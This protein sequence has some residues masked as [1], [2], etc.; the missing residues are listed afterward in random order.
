MLRLIEEGF[1]GWEL[2]PLDVALAETPL[3]SDPLG[4]WCLRCGQSVG[5]GEVTERGCASCRGRATAIRA[6]VRLAPYG[7]EFARRL[8]RIKHAC[9]FAMG[10]EVGRL[11]AA[12]VERTLTPELR[13][14]LLIPVPMPWLR[15]WQR[16][17]DHAD[18]MARSAASLL[19]IPLWQPLR[20]RN[21]PCQVS[22]TRTERRA[23]RDRFTVRSSRNAW[24]RRAAEAGVVGLVDDVRTTGATLEQAARCL[25]SLGV[26]S[27]VAI[28]AAVVANPRRRRRT[29]GPA[30]TLS[31]EVGSRSG[32]ASG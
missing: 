16:G 29:T 30:W 25:R 32:Q 20:Q 24:R 15:R 18:L 12:Q 28:V 6:T 26:E 23:V 1:L 19:G 3:E 8:L 14:R 10:E 22:R 31:G 2:P 9:W 21:G 11:L 17:I 27:V 4:S 5:P 7:G 13:P